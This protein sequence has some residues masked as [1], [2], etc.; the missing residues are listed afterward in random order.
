[1][2]YAG[3][4]VSYSS[5]KATRDALSHL[6][7][8]NGYSDED[9]TKPDRIR[10]LEMVLDDYCDMKSLEHFPKLQ[11]VCLIQQ[12]IRRI[13]GLDRCMELERLLLNENSIERIEGLQNCRKLQKLYLPFNCIQEIGT[14]L[15]GL[16]ELK[17]PG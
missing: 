7:A 17:V 8:A 10:N 11:S 5:P 6:L 12:D 4:D 3:D 15:A 14:S 9:L 16:V 1:M 2:S 13:Q